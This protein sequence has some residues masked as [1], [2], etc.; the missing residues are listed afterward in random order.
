MHYENL[1]IIRAALTREPSEFQITVA[2]AVDLDS[3]DTLDCYSIYI[4]KRL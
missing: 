1:S 3:V 2:H 4:Y